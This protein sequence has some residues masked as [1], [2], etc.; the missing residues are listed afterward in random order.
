MKIFL[1]ILGIMAAVLLF[2]FFVTPWGKRQMGYMAKGRQIR[3]NNIRIRESAKRLQNEI[4]KFDYVNNIMLM[5]YND[6]VDVAREGVES[7]IEVGVTDE[8]YI[9]ELKEMITCPTDGK[10]QGFEI[11]IIVKQMSVA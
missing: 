5:P 11:K 1:T 7:Y 3:I 2:I 6:N 9:E 10:W 4:M 8:K